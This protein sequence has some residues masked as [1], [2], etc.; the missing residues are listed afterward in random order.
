MSG[1]INVISRTQQIIVDPSSAA[2]S[3]I[4]AGPQGPA[5][6]AGPAGA[7]TSYTSPQSINAQTGTTYTLATTDLGKLITLSNAAAITLTVPQDSAVT[8]AVGAWCEIFQL[9]AGQITVVA[10]SGAT[11]RTTP[12]AKVRAQYARAYLQKIS[13]NTWALAGDLAA[14]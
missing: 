9:G 1:E 4:N 8:W 14:T 12:T 6:P 2:V 7:D 11:L 3:I 13:A 10:G 5:G